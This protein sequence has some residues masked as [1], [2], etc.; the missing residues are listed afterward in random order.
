MLSSIDATGAARP[1]ASS[2]GVISGDRCEKRLSV[3][4]RAMPKIQDSRLERPSYRSI[5]RYTLASG[6]Q[7]AEHPNRPLDAPRV[8]KYSPLV[9]VLRGVDDMSG[10]RI[11]VG[12]NDRRH[13]TRYE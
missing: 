10:S 6:R 9:R 4:R 3:A 13:R 8:A 5:E 12:S 11:A 7:A 1:R 2:S